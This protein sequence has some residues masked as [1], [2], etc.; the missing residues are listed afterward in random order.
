MSEK[1][2]YDLNGILDFLGFD[3]EFKSKSEY[4]FN[5]N[6]EAVTFSWGQ[7]LIPKRGIRE[8]VQNKIS[9]VKDTPIEKLIMMYQV[10]F[11]VSDTDG[12]RIGMINQNV[13]I[14]FRYDK[15]YK[16]GDINKS[17]YECCFYILEHGIETNDFFIITGEHIFPFFSY[18]IIDNQ[19][20]I[21]SVTVSSTPME[22]YFV[23]KNLYTE[24]CCNCIHLD[25]GSKC[26]LEAECKNN[27]H[28]E[29]L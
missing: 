4:P 22:R 3:Y 13:T 25:S 8:T 26:I 24:E 27:E 17:I 7:I 1:K 10:P 9:D 28:F 19:Y 21:G 6:R 18:Y 12:V 23:P 16:Y 15:T 29:F 5:R 20:G 2:Y 11:K 14:S